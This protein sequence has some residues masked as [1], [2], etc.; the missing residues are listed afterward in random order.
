MKLIIKLVR[1]FLVAKTKILKGQYFTDDNITTKR[2]GGG[3]SQW[4][5]VKL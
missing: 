1:K 2:S 3:I 4:K 5:L